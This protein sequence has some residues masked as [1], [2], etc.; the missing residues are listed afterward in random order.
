MALTRVLTPYSA[1]VVVL[2][3]SLVHTSYID[4]VENLRGTINSHVTKAENLICCRHNVVRWY[5]NYRC[6]RLVRKF[7][8]INFK[9]TE[10]SSLLQ[11][12][13]YLELYVAFAEAENCQAHSQ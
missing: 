8:L 3:L 4:I 13:P 12:E 2:K 5:K 10:W 1:G 9:T 7:T 11:Q 6:Q